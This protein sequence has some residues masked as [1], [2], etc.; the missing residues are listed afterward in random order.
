[1][2]EPPD[3][4]ELVGDDVPPEELARL[5]RVDA[6]LRS[7]PAP[8]PEVPQSV[9]TAVRRISSVTPLWTRRRLAGALALAAALS[10]L[11]FGIGSWIGGEDFDARATVS[12]AATKNAP[13]AWGLI[14]L[15]PRDEASG[16]WVAEVEVSGLPRL[17]EGGFYALWLAKD[18]KYA[19]T[20]GTFNVATD[21]TTTVLMNASYELANYDEWVVTAW[22]PDQ[23]NEKAPWLLTASAKNV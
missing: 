19:A 5:E 15:G 2:K 22:L 13:G 6:L 12:L 21:G 16:N 18:G 1:M 8:P 11:F 17:P 7:A 10:A 4:R 3:L 23:D 20:C 9:T 14:R